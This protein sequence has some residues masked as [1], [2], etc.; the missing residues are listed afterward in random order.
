MAMPKALAGPFKKKQT[1]AKPIKEYGG[2]A[3][4]VSK[5][6][7]SGVTNRLKKKNDNKK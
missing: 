1:Q 4:P 3:S 7:K 5:K 2:K 6:T